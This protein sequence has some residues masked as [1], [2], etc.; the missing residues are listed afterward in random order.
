MSQ[1]VFCCD[2]C[3]QCCRHIALF[4]A[5][6]SWLINEDGQCRYFDAKLN[7]CSIYKLRPLICRVE[8]GYWLYFSHMPYYEYLQR[9]KEM[10]ACLATLK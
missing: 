4:G 10:C 2:G 5:M 1:D 9:T 8:E 3:G 7:Q 6:Y